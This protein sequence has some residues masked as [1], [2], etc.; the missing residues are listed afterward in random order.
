MTVYNSVLME[1]KQ[2]NSSSKSQDPLIPLWHLMKDK[3]SKKDL[4][5]YKTK[6]KCRSALEEMNT[7]DLIYVY[8]A[9]L[10]AE[11]SLSFIKLVEDQLLSR[12][13]IEM[14]HN[15]DFDKLI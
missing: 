4:S 10:H 12:L 6:K 5:F 14:E 9:A 15:L 1:T 13:A 7:E 3:I 11:A 2:S 8:K